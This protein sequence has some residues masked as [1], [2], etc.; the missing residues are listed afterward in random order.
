MTRRPTI[1]AAML[2]AAPV[3]PEIPLRDFVRNPARAHLHASGDGRTI[4]YMPPR[5]RRMSL[6][7]QPAGCD[8][9]PVRATAGKERDVA[10]CFRKGAGRVVRLK[11]LGGD[12]NTLVVVSHRRG[13]DA[14][15][16]T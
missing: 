1:A 2:A 4:A 15:D 16:L 8:A 5:E 7:V 6:P 14:K 3:S 9:A 13:R 10:D 11:D 12:E